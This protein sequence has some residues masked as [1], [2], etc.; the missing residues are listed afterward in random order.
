MGVRL[1]WIAVEDGDGSALLDRLGLEACGTASDEVGSDY[2]CAVLPSGWFLLVS[3][4]AR[5][6]IEDLPPAASAHGFVLGGEVVE[7]VNFSR[8]LG[9]RDG[10]QTWTVVHDPE[11]GPDDVT[12][13]GEPPGILE[14]I[15]AELA[16][17]QEAQPEVDYMFDVPVRLGRELCGYSSDEAPAVEWAVLQP[18]RRERT[19]REAPQ[20]AARIRSEVLPWLQSL[21]WAQPQ[22]LRSLE[23]DFQRVRRG[24][25][26]WM[27]IQYRDDPNRLW[28]DISFVVLEGLNPEARG[29]LRGRVQEARPSIRRR[30]QNLL[31]AAIGKRPSYGERVDAVIAQARNDLLAIERFLTEGEHNPRLSIY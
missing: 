2:A 25:R 6:K 30:V 9:F 13:V 8:L 24:E 19:L 29:R 10:R 7:N 20:L 31:T 27:G 26:E 22:P 17:Q 21:G 23:F 14:E 18:R 5:L 16:R 15:R 1:N 12:I 28:I 4:A 11:V 3:G